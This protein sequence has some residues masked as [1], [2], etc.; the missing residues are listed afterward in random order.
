MNS[1]RL[2]IVMVSMTPAPRFPFAVDRFTIGNGSRRA[3][4]RKGHAEMRRTGCRSPQGRR[5]AAARI[6]AAEGSRPLGLAR[7]VE[8]R[9]SHAREAADV[10]IVVLGG[11]A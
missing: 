7:H 5:L 4:H 8:D 3:N 11:D 2:L 1:V 6:L 10:A 9:V